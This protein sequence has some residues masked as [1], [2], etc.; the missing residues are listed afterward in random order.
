[1]WKALKV[2]FLVLG[3]FALAGSARAQTMTAAQVQKLF[4]G[5]QLSLSCMDGTNAQ[6]R[7]EMARGFG[8]L[9]VTYQSPGQASSR[10]AGRVRADASS[11]CFRFTK[12]TDG[13]EACYGVSQLGPSLFQLSSGGVPVCSLALH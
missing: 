4:V 9:T 8:K 6:G 11:L 2:S 10:D 13:Q 1:M 5:K 12:L 7:Y 3:T